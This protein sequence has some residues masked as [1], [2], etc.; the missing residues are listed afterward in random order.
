[1]MQADRHRR[2]SAV[3]VAFALACVS[4]FMPR[5]CPAIVNGAPASD[6]RFAVDFAWAVA[7][8][9]PAAGGV[10]T[11]QVVSPTWVLTAGHCASQNMR[12]MAGNA[13]RTLAVAVPVTRAIRHPLYDAT[14]GE[15]DVGLLQLGKPLEV[16]PV[17]LMRRGEEPSLLREGAYAVIAGWGKRSSSLP[18]SERLIVSDVELRSLTRNKT[19]FTYFDP[20]SGPCG[21]DSGGPL[22]L[23]RA[24]GTRVLAGIASRV[25][26]DLCAQGGGF[27]M[28]VN[29]AQVRDFIEAHVRDLR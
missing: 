3:R 4:S 18:F 28:Y 12:V 21:G 26:G 19:R 23:A 14:T 22:L 17:T 15:H 2:G 9:N 1:M 13:N 7:L 8:V 20:V 27:G 29:V 5:S 24:D 11:A 25:A 16:K 10:C 6:E